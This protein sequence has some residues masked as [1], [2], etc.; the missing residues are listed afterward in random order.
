MFQ[1]TTMKTRLNPAAAYTAIGLETG[2]PNA[3]SHGLV[4]MLF[5]GALMAVASAGGHLKGGRIGPKGEAISKAID[6]INSGLKASLDM[7]A[8]GDLSER[9]GALYD[10][11]CARLLHANLNNDP[12]A[13]EEVSRLL[14]EL[15][16]AWEEIAGD[17]AVL[18]SNRTAA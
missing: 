16:G 15:K 2:V 6:I 13:L 11:L 9:L 5:D 1:V 17:P 12:A 8:G 18:S 14:V 10:Y 7:Q 3:N 4:L